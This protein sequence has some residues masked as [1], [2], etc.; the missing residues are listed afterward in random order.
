M[1]REVTHVRLSDEAT[2]VLNQYLQSLGNVKRNKTECINALI[3]SWGSESSW[4][5]MTMKFQPSL[6]RI[7]ETTKLEVQRKE[8][9]LALKK[10]TIVWDHPDLELCLYRDLIGTPRCRDPK[11]PLKTDDLRLE[12]CLAC[13]KL[14]NNMV[15]AYRDYQMVQRAFRVGGQKIG[16]VVG[17]KQQLELR[18]TERDDWKQRYQQDTRTMRSDFQIKLNRKEAK[19]NQLEKYADDLSA[20]RKTLKMRINT[21][22]LSDSDPQKL[23]NLRSKYQTVKTQLEEAL[24]ELEPLRNKHDELLRKKDQL[25]KELETTKNKGMLVMCPEKGKV[26]LHFCQNKCPDFYKCGRYEDIRERLQSEGKS[27][28]S[29]TV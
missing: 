9:N 26:S 22:E 21:F 6:L 4:K 3:A 20:E 8:I 17:L 13:Q 14:R 19:I 27:L 2:R 28:F 18:E 5:K 7:V 10:D 24:S 23:E 1:K 29:D 12:I 25:S 15:E 16:L 11:P